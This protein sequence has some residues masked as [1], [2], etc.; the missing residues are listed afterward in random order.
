MKKKLCI[1]LSSLMV[2]C[3]AFSS[4]DGRDL[5]PEGTFTSGIEGPAVDAAGNLYA[6]NYATKGTIGLIKS[7]GEH[8]LFVTLPDGSVGNG[9][10]FNAEGVIHRRFMS[11]N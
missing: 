1:L 9:I 5:V 3:V 11:E 8:G 7:S 10:R 4:P 2:S 6:V